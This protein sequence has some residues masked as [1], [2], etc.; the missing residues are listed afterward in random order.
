MPQLRAT[1][2]SAVQGQEARVGAGVGG[3]LPC[4]RVAEPQPGHGACAVGSDPRES[5]GR[6]VRSLTVAKLASDQ[7]ELGA[8]PFSARVWGQN[9]LVGH[10]VLSC[11]WEPSVL[12]VFKTP[13][14]HVRAEALWYIPSNTFSTRPFVNEEWLVDIHVNLRVLN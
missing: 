9:S 12:S 4:R 7:R 3:L 5:R 14:S 2:L 11:S 8:T 6:S 1:R 13:S 10:L